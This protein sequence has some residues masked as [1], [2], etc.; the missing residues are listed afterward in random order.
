M[1]VIAIP[2]KL[3]GWVLR[4]AIESVL[5]MVFFVALMIGVPMAFAW[6]QSQ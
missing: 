3:A 2:F 4:I 1:F 5:R 6:W